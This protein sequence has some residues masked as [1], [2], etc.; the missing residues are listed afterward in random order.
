MPNRLR[1]S[2]RALLANGADLRPA[3]SAM[4][5]VGDFDPRVVIEVLARKQVPDS[6]PG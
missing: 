4:T 5:T 1:P 3:R 6:D 2:A